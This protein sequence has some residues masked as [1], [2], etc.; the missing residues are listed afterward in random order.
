MAGSEYGRTARDVLVACLALWSVTSLVVIAVWRTSPGVR[1]M[2]RC[3]AELQGARGRLEEA[4]AEWGRRREELQELLRKGARNQTHLHRQADQL[5]QSLRNSEASV[6]SCLQGR[7]TI[8]ES[9][10]KLEKS[11]E[12][13]KNIE[14]NLRTEISAQEGRI[15]MLRTNITRTYSSQGLCETELRSTVVLQREAES[16]RDDCEMQQR[17][18]SKLFFECIKQCG[19]EDQRNM[20]GYCDRPASQPGLHCAHPA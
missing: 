8:N 20:G 14:T 11:I 12:T 18:L 3:K 2:E 1:S 17:H 19:P 16:R 4:R 15:E 13:Q 9:I 5:T 10:S 7:A 6:R